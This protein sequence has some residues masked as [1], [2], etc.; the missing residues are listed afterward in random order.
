[1]SEWNGLC[2]SKLRILIRELEVFYPDVVFHPYPKGFNCKWDLYEYGISYFIGMEFSNCR[3]ANFQPVVI[4]FGEI[5][6]KLKPS[7]C[8]F[9]VKV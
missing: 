5:L 1:M 7:S 4:P 3:F 6:Q 8:Y 9:E 2:L